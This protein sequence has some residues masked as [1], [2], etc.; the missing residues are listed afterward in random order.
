[1]SNKKQ[2]SEHQPKS[3]SVTPRQAFIYSAL[4]GWKNDG[5]NPWHNPISI[6]TILAWA[7]S[8]LS[9]ITETNLLLSEFEKLTLEGLFFE[10]HHGL[11]DPACYFCSYDP[12]FLKEIPD[13]TEHITYWETLTEDYD[14]NYGFSTWRNLG[15][16]GGQGSQGPSGSPWGPCLGTSCCAFE[17]AVEDCTQGLHFSSGLKVV[18]KGCGQDVIREELSKFPSGIWMKDSSFPSKPVVCKHCVKSCDALIR[19][20]WQY[21]NFDH[22][23]TTEEFKKKWPQSDAER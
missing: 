20:S 8:H 4:E 12:N 13:G 11:F 1:M 22:E 2:N 7:E 3:E 21:E 17:N 14:E 10:V 5:P 19:L 23:R 9:G 18:C 15:L 6:D 16:C